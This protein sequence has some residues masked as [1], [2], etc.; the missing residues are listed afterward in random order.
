[1]GVNCQTYYES[2]PNGPGRILVPV[3]ITGSD[4]SIENSKI[5]MPSQP[6]YVYFDGIG[7]ASLGLNALALDGVTNLASHFSD[8]TSNTIGL[9][10][11]LYNPQYRDNY[12]IYT[13][14]KRRIG[15]FED[16]TIARANFAEANNN[17]VVPVTEG[18]PPRTRAS[19]PGTTFQAV[20]TLF[21]SDGRQ[22]QALQPGGLKVAM[23]DGSVR[24]I[25]P[26]VSEATFW[27]LVTPAAGDI[28]EL[29]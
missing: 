15:H 18:F 6:G 21:D 19:R 20:P 24:T 16:F 14:I 8:G 25:H 5:P 4:Y 3:Y 27:G 23:L 11:R 17:D 2:P 12:F 1:M 9:S 28:A 7:P 10:E 29:D 13:G 22:L 26:G